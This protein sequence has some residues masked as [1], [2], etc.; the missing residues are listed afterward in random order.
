[1]PQ[2]T[3]TQLDQFGIISDKPAHTLPINAFSDGVNVKF[4]D[5]AARKVQGYKAVLGSLSTTPTFLRTMYDQLCYCGT[6]AVY[7]VKNGTHYEITRTTTGANMVFDGSMND[8]DDSKPWWTLGNGWSINTTT[9]KAHCNGSQGAVSSL[10]QNISIVQGRSY[11][12]TF[13]LSNYSA[14]TLTPKVGG[15]AGTARS[16]NGTFTETITASAI[17]DTLLA[18]EANSTFV[19]DVTD[20]SCSQTQSYY[21]GTANLGWN[22]DAL[23][24]V[25]YLNNAVDTPQMWNPLSQSTKLDNLTHW[26]AG[27]TIRSLRFFKSFLIGIF[28]TKG[29]IAFPQMIKWSHPTEPGQ[30]PVSWDVGDASK[31]AGETVIDETGSALVE[32]MPLRDQFIVYKDDQ[33]W[34]LT[35]VGPPY[36]WKVAPVVKS[37]GLLAT[38]CVAM[39]EGQHYCM[40]RDDLYVFDGHNAKSLLTGRNRAWLEQK[41]DPD[42]GQRAFVSVNRTEREVWFCFPERSASWCSL[43]L[44]YNYAQNTWGIRDLP[45]VSSM[46]E[47]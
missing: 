13:T 37:L 6:S 29:G 7:T 19:G 24:G 26:P 18:L 2:L 23:G 40:S 47:V 21:N 10:S 5:G 39:V 12:V 25:G 9:D 8:Y 11:S 22:G 36:V 30:V 20:I 44:T 28:P 14:G 32:G 1:M 38:N 35:Y 42:N 17:T 33:I 43:A 15:V 3:V 16:A 31:L 45:N 27:T 34:S 46:S 4:S 41:I